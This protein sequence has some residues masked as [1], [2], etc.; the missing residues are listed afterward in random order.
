MRIVVGVGLGVLVDGGVGV[1]AIIVG[2]VRVDV[3]LGGVRVDVGLGVTLGMAGRVMSGVVCSATLAGPQAI[4][5]KR[6][7]SASVGSKRFMCNLD[8][9]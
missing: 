6:T 3:G 8:T 2:G 7:T 1:A 4:K 9:Y 5:K